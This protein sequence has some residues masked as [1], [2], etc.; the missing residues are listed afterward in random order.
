MIEL[1]TNT[2][3]PGKNPGSCMCSDTVVT[4]DE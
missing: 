4:L 2:A 1:I 3:L